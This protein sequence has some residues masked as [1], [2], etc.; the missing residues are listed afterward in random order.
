MI[1]LGVLHL[2][3][4]LGKADVEKAIELFTRASNGFVFE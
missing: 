3:D 1:N 2:R 4:L